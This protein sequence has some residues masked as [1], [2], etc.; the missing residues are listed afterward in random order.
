MQV[1][2]LGAPS[3]ASSS[4]SSA[5]SPAQ[6]S[7]ERAIAKL[8]SQPA[9]PTQQ[10]VKNQNSISP[11]ELSAIQPNR[12]DTETVSEMV[13]EAV[14]EETQPAQKP[15]QDPALSRQFAQ[16][17]RQEKILRQKVQQQEQA[18]KSREAALVAR[19]AQLSSSQPDLSKY[20]P[21]DRLSQ[22][23]LSVLAEAGISY[24]QL[25][26]QLINQQPTDP[27]V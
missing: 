21:R 15:P 19:E 10:V 14:A 17:A 20:I 6:A 22:D 7:R 16:L 1:K 27:R 8:T 13:D 12:I 25:T 26:Q 24:D 5:Q 23:T 4:P 3:T 2:P 11:E 9:Q 18:M